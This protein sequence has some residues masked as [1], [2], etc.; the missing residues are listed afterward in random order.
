MIDATHIDTGAPIQQEVGDRDGLRFV[1][2]LLTVSSPRVNQRS[3]AIDET[4]Q[5]V[6]PT[7]PRCHVRRQ[8]RTARQQE[9]SGVLV[10]VVEHGV[11]AVLPLAFPVHVRAGV[12]QHREQRRILRRDVCGTLAE[13]KHRVVDAFPDVHGCEELSRARNVAAPDGIAERLDVAFLEFGHELRPRLK[14][15]LAGDGELRIGELERP[16]CRCGVRSHRVETCERRSVAGTRRANQILCELALLFEAA[17]NRG[18]VRSGHGRPPS[19]LARVRI[20][21]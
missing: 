12:D 6:E 14:A 21:G 2:R 3:I 20:M 9:S 17:E 1:E 19:I 18:T 16:Q 7:E 13:G 10:G 8:H 15:S 11:G 4:L 5:V